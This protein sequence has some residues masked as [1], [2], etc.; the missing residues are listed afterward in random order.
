[1]GCRATW[2]CSCVPQNCC[3]ALSAALCSS[4]YFCIRCYKPDGRF[5]A[6]IEWFDVAHIAAGMTLQTI[7][8]NTTWSYATNTGPPYNLHCT[9][10]MTKILQIYIWNA[11][12]GSTKA[13]VNAHSTTDFVEF[14]MC[15]ICTKNTVMRPLTIHKWFVKKVLFNYWSFP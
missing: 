5:S 11:L 6:Y 4:L 12:L 15:N 14:K 7:L 2:G 10:S 9:R 1:M 13:G 3:L 8:P